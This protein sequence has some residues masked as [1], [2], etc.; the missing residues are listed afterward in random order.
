MESVAVL[1]DFTPIFIGMH[2]QL[3]IRHAPLS[4]MKEGARVRHSYGS[5]APSTYGS[6]GPRRANPSTDSVGR[7]GQRRAD[8]GRDAL[9][10]HLRA[11]EK[12]VLSARGKYLIVWPLIQLAIQPSA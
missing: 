5:Y 1:T 6:Y 8:R 9:R 12:R 10:E 11:W 2:R 4:P 7:R 3:G